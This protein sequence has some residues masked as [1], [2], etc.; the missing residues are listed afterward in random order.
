MCACVRVFLFVVCVRA[1]V[2][3]CVCACHDVDGV[4]MIESVSKH[5][6]V[7][8]YTRVYIDMRVF[9]LGS[10]LLRVARAREKMS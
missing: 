9:L 7:Y 4:C 10:P 3:V 5:A 6:Q 8:V 2:G 1:C